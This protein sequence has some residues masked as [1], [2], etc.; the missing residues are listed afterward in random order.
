MTN[1]GWFVYKPEFGEF[2]ISHFYYKGKDVCGEL[3]KLKKEAYM[4]G[5]VGFSAGKFQ[6]QTVSQSP[7][8]RALYDNKYVQL[9]PG[10]GLS[11]P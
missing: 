9:L 10:Y 1:T 5:R 8:C 11:A 6:N 7:K 4:T 3:G 2:W